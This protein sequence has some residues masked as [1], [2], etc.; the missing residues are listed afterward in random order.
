MASSFVL[1]FVCGF[2]MLALPIDW[3]VP[4]AWCIVLGSAVVVWWHYSKRATTLE[5]DH[6]SGR[7]AIT[8]PDGNSHL[9]TTAD[10]MAIGRSAPDQAADVDESD[11]EDE[12]EDETAEESLP[13]EDEEPQIASDHPTITYR[14]SSGQEQT[15]ALAKWNSSDSTTWL[16]RWLTEKL[17]VKPR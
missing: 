17:R 7:V 6:F 13:I 16:V 5:Y 2:G 1:I 10:V 15:V 11:D 4:A 14:D 3:L 9:F 12:D 8:S